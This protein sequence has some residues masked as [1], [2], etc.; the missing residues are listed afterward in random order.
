MGRLAVD[1]VDNGRAVAHRPH[2]HYDCYYSRHLAD[3][4][5]MMRGGCSS[6]PEPGYVS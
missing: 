5:A 6:L 2:S 4:H 1:A 3:G